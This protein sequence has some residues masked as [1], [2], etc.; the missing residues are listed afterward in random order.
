ME[1]RLPLAML[2]KM[3]MDLFVETLTAHGIGVDE[4]STHRG[5]KRKALDLFFGSHKGKGP[6]PSFLKLLYPKELLFGT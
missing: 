1:E 2:S 3:R 4:V 5:D 6:N